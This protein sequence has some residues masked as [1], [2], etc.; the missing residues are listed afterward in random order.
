MKVCSR[1]NKEK[2]TDAFQLRRA[3]KDG[4]TAAC[5]DCLGV[6]DRNRP[7]HK[8]RLEKDK[9]RYKK[10]RKEKSKDFIN[11]DRKRIQK[12]RNENPLKYKAQCK[13][14]NSLRDGKITRPENCERCGKSC[15]PQGHHWSYEE[16]Y[17]LD[18]E[19]LCVTCH[20]DEHKRLREEG[21]DPDL[22]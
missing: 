19:W 4:L 22:K 8:E 11:K 14:N 16:D 20:A 21:R 17:W 2:G 13:V 3:S 10:K 5:K 7:N 12:Y 18:V 6:Y 9:A 1:C 15:K